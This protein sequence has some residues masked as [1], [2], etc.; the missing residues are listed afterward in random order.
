VQNPKEPIHSGPVLSI[1]LDW[2]IGGIKTNKR[3]LFSY[4][5]DLAVDPEGNVYVLDSL[6]RAVK[7]YDQAGRFVWSIGRTGQGPGEFQGIPYGLSY[8]PL[9]KSLMVM[10]PAGRLSWFLPDGGFIRSVKLSQ[11]IVF[12]ALCDSAGKIYLRKDAQDGTHRLIVL[13]AEG[14]GVLSEIMKIPQKSG[15]NPFGPYGSWTIDAMDSLIYGFGEPYEL[16]VFDSGGRLIRKIVKLYDPVRIPKF[17][18]DKYRATDVP[19][20][21]TLP[22]VTRTHMP[23]FGNF[24]VDD[25]G[26]LFVHTWDGTSEGREELYDIF[27]ADGR[28]F[29]RVSLNLRFYRD[30]HVCVLRK[31]KLYALE[32][33]EEEV[34]IVRR[35][36]VRWL[37]KEG[38]NARP[39]R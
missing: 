25:R 22:R 11:G 8:H 15:G 21:L 32:E 35:Y 14:R 4:P 7:K 5:K 33:G 16:Q 30:G 18:L 36:S 29:G 27:D 20:G 9:A 10:D 38:E 12:S 3:D 23:A 39:V 19:P 37:V 26:R 31:D 13:D 28:F 24:F 2:T 1:S 34:G 17:M 6:D